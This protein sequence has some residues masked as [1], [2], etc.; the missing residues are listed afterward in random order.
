M[1]RRTVVALLGGASTTLAGTVGAQTSESVRLL[2]IVLPYGEGDAKSQGHLALLRE[3]L[4]KLGWR[5]GRNLRIE[6]RWTSGDRD[7]TMMSAREVFASRPDVILARSTLVTAAVLR[8][9][10]AIPTVF[11]VVS[12]PVGDGFVSSMARPGGNVTGF[13]NVEASL[14][15]KWVQLLREVDPRATRIAVLYGPK[16]SAGGGSYYLRLAEEAVASTAVKVIA[17]PVQEVVDADHGIDAFAREAGSSALLVTPD[18]TTTRLRSTIVSAAA[19]TKLAAIYPFRDFTEEGGLISYGTD[20]ADQYR[21][22]AV[23]VDRIL[24]GAKPVDLPVRNESGKPASNPY[25]FFFLT[26][27]TRESGSANSATVTQ[28][29]PVVSTSHVAALNFTASDCLASKLEFM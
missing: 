19:R 4:A 5:D 28:S 21:K 11:V 15:G 20:V 27:G 14:C 3:E 17:L 8:E 26:T 12:D 23:Y 10:R 16:T 9:T 1:R 6:I 7:R 18:A 13:T 22:A 29:V 2:G 24:R 25:R